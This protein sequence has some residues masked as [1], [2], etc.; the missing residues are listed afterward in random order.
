MNDALHHMRI[1]K[2]EAPG[3]RRRNF[4]DSITYDFTTEPLTTMTMSVDDDVTV[5]QSEWITAGKFSD[6]LDLHD[7]RQDETP[8]RLDY[9][10]L[11]ID[12]LDD[13]EI[14]SLCKKTKLDAKSFLKG[15]MMSI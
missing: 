13:W 12:I 1:G 11:I 8:D 6:K 15:F 9:R 2:C 3:R 14:Q 10:S 5:R 7:F 4:D